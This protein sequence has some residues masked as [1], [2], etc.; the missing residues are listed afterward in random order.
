MKETKNNKPLMIVAACLIIAML[1]IC[2]STTSI[3]KG[4]YGATGEEQTTSDSKDAGGNPQT[5]TVSLFV[6]WTISIGA[7][8]YAFYYFKHSKA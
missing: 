1:A 3:A 5:G 2:L 4:T 8:G 7:A 6:I